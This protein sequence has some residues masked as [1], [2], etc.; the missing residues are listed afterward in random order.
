MDHPLVA[1]QSDLS[2][3]TTYLSVISTLV[4]MIFVTYEVYSLPEPDVVF[5]FGVDS[6]DPQGLRRRASDGN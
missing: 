3:H 5:S 6:V 1:N 4:A 2:N